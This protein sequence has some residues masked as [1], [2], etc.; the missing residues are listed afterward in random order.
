[1]LPTV[2][3]AQHFWSD[4]AQVF[5]SANRLRAGCVCVR[6]PWGAYPQCV[7]SATVGN[8]ATLCAT[9][10]GSSKMWLSANLVLLVTEQGVA[11]WWKSIPPTMVRKTDF[12]ESTNASF[13]CIG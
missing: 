4:P 13:T 3:F 10:N 7:H 6:L 5:A 11:Q 2:S 1:M 9:P 12:L 8:I